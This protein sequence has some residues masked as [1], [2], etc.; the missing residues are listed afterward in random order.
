MVPAAETT[1][2][3]ATPVLVVRSRINT[4]CLTSTISSTWLNNGTA[5]SV[6]TSVEP[7]DTLLIIYAVGR[8]PG[9]NSTLSLP[10]PILLTNT[11]CIC[12]FQVTGLCNVLSVVIPTSI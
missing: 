11:S 4:L 6:N 12:F 7:A 1:A 10:I 3:A 9:S 2:V 5:V 8:M